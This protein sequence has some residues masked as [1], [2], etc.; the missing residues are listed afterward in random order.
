M[1]PRLEHSAAFPVQRI[2]QQKAGRITER[3]TLVH[4][5]QALAP[6]AFESH[7]FRKGLKRLRLPVAAVHSH[8]PKTFG[9]LTPQRFRDGI[10]TPPLPLDM[11]GAFHLTHPV[12]T[13]M[14]DVAGQRQAQHPVVKGIVGLGKVAFLFELLDNLQCD[15]CPLLI[16]Q[17]VHQMM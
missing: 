7:Y 5:H 17:T 14:L 9:M 8:G 2:G 6:I 15:L 13:G 12:F 16:P 3:F 11:P 10:H 1:T 4:D